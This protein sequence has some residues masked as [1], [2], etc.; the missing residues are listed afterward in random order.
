[1]HIYVLDNTTTRTISEYRVL[2]REETHQQQGL[3]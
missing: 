3:F 2:M 1:M